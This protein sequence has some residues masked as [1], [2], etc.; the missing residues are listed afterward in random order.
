MALLAGLSAG[1]SGPAQAQARFALPSDLGKIIGQHTGQTGRPVVYLVQEMH[2][3][4]EVQQKTAEI[5]KWIQLEQGGSRSAGPLLVAVEGAAGRIPVENLYA[6]KN[7]PAKRERLLELVRQGK[8]TGSDYFALMNDEPV[9]YFG[10]EDESLYREGQRLIAAFFTDRNQTRIEDLNRFWV[11]ASKRELNP[12]AYYLNFLYHE[13][14]A[15]SMAPDVI[16]AE[17][18]RT[19]TQAGLGDL[20]RSLA[21][22]TAGQ[23]PGERLESMF[24]RIFPVALKTAAEKDFFRA[25]DFFFNLEQMLWL[26]IPGG[27][28]R[29]MIADYY[30]SGA[31]WMKFAF[32]QLRRTRA[33]YEPGLSWDEGAWQNIVRNMM[34]FYRLNERRNQAFVQNTLAYMRD[35]GVGTAALVTGGYHTHSV[36]ELLRQQNVNFVVIRPEITRVVEENPYYDLLLEQ[37]KAA[38]KR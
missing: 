11:Q 27:R 35:R 8:L 30:D 7:S 12:L 22:A 5:L 25:Q 24:R 29:E 17:L 18:E 15:G 16:L 9:L 31:P 33:R 1:W 14:V 3:D 6:Q 20:W 2:C 37:A 4:F 38:S 32:A 13:S 19:L 36:S 34:T 10:A 26:S 28:A 23:E 21:E